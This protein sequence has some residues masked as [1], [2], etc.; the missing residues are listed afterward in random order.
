MKDC[1]QKPGKSLDAWLRRTI[2]KGHLYPKD[3]GRQFPVG[4]GCKDW[5]MLET[6]SDDGEIRID[7][8]GDPHF[9]RQQIAD[10]V[11]SFCKLNHLAI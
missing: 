3:A 4:Y 2:A 10:Y 9:S 6:V 7:H 11:A 8:A 5:P 1:P